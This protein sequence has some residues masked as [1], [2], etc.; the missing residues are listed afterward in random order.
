MKNG[1]TAIKIVLIFSALAIIAAGN[2]DLS[3]RT[4]QQASSL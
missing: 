3:V 2:M 4:E 1:S